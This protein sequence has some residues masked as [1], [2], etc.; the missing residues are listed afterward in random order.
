MRDLLAVLGCDADAC[1][2]QV[3][4]AAR[5]LTST[6]EAAGWQVAVPVQAF[7]DEDDIDLLTQDR[8]PA[9]PVRVLDL[10]RAEI[11]LG[12]PAGVL[13]RVAARRASS[14]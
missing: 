14:G 9:H 7:V 13:A 1:E 10:E 8:C 11:E 6:A 3:V 5:G 12:L 4:A 2:D